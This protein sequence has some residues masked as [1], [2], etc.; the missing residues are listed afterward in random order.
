MCAAVSCSALVRAAVYCV[1]YISQCVSFQSVLIF[2]SFEPVLHKHGYPCLYGRAV[3]S[4]PTRFLLCFSGLV[5]RLV[6]RGVVRRLCWL[7]APRS[8]GGALHFSRVVLDSDQGQDQAFFTFWIYSLVFGCI[9]K[10]FIRP[11]KGL[12]RLC[13]ASQGL[14]KAF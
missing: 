5:V 7:C 4:C 13:K 14:I 1:S 3:L 8:R 11:Y 2:H 12:I 10:G 6:V 9:Y